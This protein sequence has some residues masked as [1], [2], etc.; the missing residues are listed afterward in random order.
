[1]VVVSTVL[2][3]RLYLRLS[4]HPLIDNSAKDR[5]GLVDSIIWTFLCICTVSSSLVYELPPRNHVG[6]QLTRRKAR[7][8]NYRQLECWSQV[9]VGQQQ[10]SPTALLF[11]PACVADIA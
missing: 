7:L 11:P 8:E 6:G 3:V 10:P 1:M 4:G 2:T 9:E 5:S